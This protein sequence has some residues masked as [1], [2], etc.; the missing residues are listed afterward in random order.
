MSTRQTS[1]LQYFNALKEFQVVFL[2]FRVEG[3]LTEM[4]MRWAAQEWEFLKMTFT[5]YFEERKKMN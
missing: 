3:Q 4:L 2:V 1:R 5:K